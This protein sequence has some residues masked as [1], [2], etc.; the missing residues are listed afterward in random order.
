MAAAER[1]LR[2]ASQS[3]PPARQALE[4]YAAQSFYQAGA[5][6]RALQTLGGIDSQRLNTG[7]RQLEQLIWARVA[8]QAALPERA[9]AALAR[10]PAQGLPLT[11]RIERLGLLAAAQR[12][13]GDPI[14][15]AKTLAEIDPLLDSPHERRANQVSLLMTLATLPSAERA[16]LSRRGP[17]RLRPWASLLDLLARHEQADAGFM[18]DFRTWRAR[19]GGSSKIDES[20]ARA[21]YATLAGDYAPE[22][23]T[24]LLLPEGGRFGGAAAAIYRGVQVAD[25]HNISG[26]RPRLT[27]TNSADDAQAAY[28]RA[29]SAG[30]QQIIGPLQKQAVDRLTE[31]SM[32]AVPTLALNRNTNARALPDD[33]VQFALAPEDEAVS[34]ANVAWRSGL[35]SALL[36]YPQGP[37][38]DRLA[39]AFRQHWRALG[40]AIAGETLYGTTLASKGNSIETLLTPDTGEFIFLVAT[41][42]DAHAIWA[43]LH[44]ANLHQRPVIATSHVHAGGQTREA[45]LAGLYFVDMP[46]LLENSTRQPAAI[47]RLRQ[48]SAGQSATL[49]RL[50]AMGLDSYRLA[51]YVSAMR[52]HPGHFFTGASGGL[53]LDGT[54]RIHRELLL[55]RFTAAG[56]IQ[57]ERIEQPQASSVK[58]SN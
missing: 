1:Y 49:D 29:L 5:T 25:E 23:D 17:G 41:A 30:A 39:S 19:Q 8:L 42:A 21:Y 47:R 24:W 58:S 33:L 48:V 32:V 51:P 13:N 31:G 11:T 38:G 2:L 40:G 14:A 37:W 4:L 34:A 46:W 26:Q 28:A 9:L 15:A 54:G 12:Q 3:Q 56:P 53:S 22:T 35:R 52:N 7:A 20:L 55:G 10:V 50:Y 57:V 16:Q 18:A 45:A 44:T 43:P 27:R 36:L 6:Q